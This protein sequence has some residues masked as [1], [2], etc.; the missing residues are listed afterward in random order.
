MVAEYDLG[1]EEGNPFVSL[2][3]FCR[4]YARGGLELGFRIAELRKAEGIEHRAMDKTA[5]RMQIPENMG[6]RA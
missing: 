6:Q 3:L 1:A 5:G 4:K 2:H